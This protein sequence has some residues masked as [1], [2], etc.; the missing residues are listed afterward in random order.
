MRDEKRKRPRSSDEDRAGNSQ[1]PGVM[2]KHAGHIAAAPIKFEGV[3]VRLRSVRR[4][5]GEDRARLCGVHGDLRFQLVETGEFLFRP[6]EIDE[7]DA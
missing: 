7:R 5:G 1:D 6:D 4:N 2:P 3:A